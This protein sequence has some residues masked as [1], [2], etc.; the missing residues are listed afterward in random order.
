MPLRRM[1]ARRGSIRS[2]RSDNVTNFVG[3]ENE[4]KRAFQEI[5]HTKIK[6]FLQ[7]NGAGW[8]IWTRKTPT[9]SHMGGVWEQ[10]IKSARNILTSLP[11]TYRTSLNGEAVTASMTEVEAVLNSRPLTTELLNDGNS[12]HPIYPSNILTM[13]SR[14][15]MPP[16]GEFVRAKIYCRKQWARVQHITKE[17]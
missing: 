4:L 7:E 17:F 10:Q 5:N 1:I 14:I 8:L 13:K 12:L 9:T 3:T 2:M 16:P 15:V 11:K 6:H